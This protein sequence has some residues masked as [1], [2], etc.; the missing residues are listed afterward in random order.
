MPSV[1]IYRKSP[2]L[3]ASTFTPLLMCTRC[4]TSH[5]SSIFF[6]SSFND[7]PCPS[8]RL[9]RTRREQY[10]IFVVESHNLTRPFG[11][12]ANAPLYPPHIFFCF[13][14]R[15]PVFPPVERI[16]LYATTQV[17][18]LTNSP[19]LRVGLLPY[20]HS[21]VY[22]WI[23]WYTKS[24]RLQSITNSDETKIYRV[25]WEVE[26]NPSVYDRSAPAGPKCTTCQLPASR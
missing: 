9:R 7:P 11:L 21:L 23:L 3:P 4:N 1:F 6:S 22:S 14:H 19:V 5:L 8:S 12:F 17:R 15:I 25:Q 18:L 24:T 26:P 2:S 10:T 16:Y 20:V 13:V